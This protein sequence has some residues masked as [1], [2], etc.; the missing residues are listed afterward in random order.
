MS[1]LISLLVRYNCLRC[2]GTCDGSKLVKSTCQLGKAEKTPSGTEHRVTERHVDG[3]HWQQPADIHQQTGWYAVN[4]W[5]LVDFD[6]TTEG[7]QRNRR[8]SATRQ[9]RH[10]ATQ[11]V[12]MEMSQCV[13]VMLLLDKFS[14]LIIEAR[15]A[16]N[17]TPSAVWSV[18]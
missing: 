9:K 12:A 11:L 15:L 2:E 13:L 3:V 1:V 18:F 16:S 10:V 8:R 5:R 4:N 7:L 6:V 14:R 17:N